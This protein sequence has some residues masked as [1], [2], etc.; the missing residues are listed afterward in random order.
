MDHLPLRH[1]EMVGIR[2]NTSQENIISLFSGTT[3]NLKYPQNGKVN[4]PH[5]QTNKQLMQVH[6]V[7]NMCIYTHFN[8][9][10][11]NTYDSSHK[12]CLERITLGIGIVARF[13][14]WMITV[15]FNSQVHLHMYNGP[16]SSEDL[17]RS[18]WSFNF[19]R[20]LSS[21]SCL[22]MYIKE[23]YV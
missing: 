10:I 2:W 11:T 9:T 23:K 5:Q 1:F 15:Q 18:T 6:L 17:Q 13:P 20:C 3:H 14:C 21:R 19:S 4:G 7:R 16:R 22:C 8:D 12:Q